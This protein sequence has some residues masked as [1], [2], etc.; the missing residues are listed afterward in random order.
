MLNLV[1]PKFPV[2][3]HGEQRHLSKFTV[4]AESMGYPREN[5]IHLKIGDIL[6]IRWANGG[7]GRVGSTR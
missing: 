4:L 3:V 5:I 1:R 7:S 2:P 6:G